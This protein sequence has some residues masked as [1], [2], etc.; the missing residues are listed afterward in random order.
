MHH[1][2]LHLSVVVSQPDSDVGCIWMHIGFMMSSPHIPMLWLCL[3][4]AGCSQKNFR[5]IQQE[6][7]LAET[8]EVKKEVAG[9]RAAALVS[10]ELL[11]L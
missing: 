1:I 5:L 2:I 8:V 4:K 7:A 9:N 6:T 3:G 10:F 11:A